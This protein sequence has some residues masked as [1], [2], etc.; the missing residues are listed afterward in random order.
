MCVLIKSF[1][2]KILLRPLKLQHA[3]TH[4]HTPHFSS[5]SEPNKALTIAQNG[6]KKV[7]DLFEFVDNNGQTMTVKKA[8]ESSNTI[9]ETAVLRG[10]KQKPSVC[11][12][13]LF[14]LNSQ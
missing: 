12:I 3:H 13:R 1:F 11:F 6:L 10:G 8:M 7:H 9:F 2:K 14:F 5:A 4:T